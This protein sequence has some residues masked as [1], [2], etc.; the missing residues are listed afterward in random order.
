MPQP[1]TLHTRS[2]LRAKLDELGP[3]VWKAAAFSVAISF[4]QLV[5]VAYMFETFDRVVGSRS[6]ETLF[7]LTVI[8]V[9]ALAVLQGLEAVRSR[10]LESAA[11]QL[12]A[13]VRQRL[14]L[15]TFSARLMRHPSGS[16][17]A[18]NDLKMVRDFV[19]SP[20]LSAVLDLPASLLFVALIF[21]I[22]PSMGM[23][24]LIGVVIQFLLGVWNQGRSLPPLREAQQASAEATQ[25]AHTVARNAQVIDSMGMFPRVQ[26]RWLG[27]QRRF[28]LLQA[29]A[30]DGAAASQAA[31][32]MLGMVQ[33]SLIMGA[34]AFISLFAMSAGPASP[35]SVVD[36]AL[37]IIASILGGR[38]LLP[39][40]QLLLQ[41][42]MVAGVLQAFR[43]L[44][45]LLQT[46]PGRKPSMEL[47]APAGPLVVDQVTTGVPGLAQLILR[48]VSFAVRPG[49]VLAV[50]GPSG[51]G[52][53]TLAR[54][55]LGTWRINNGKVRLDGVDV[56][57][58]DKD[59]LGPYLGYLPQDVELFEGS[60]AD[61]IARFGEPDAE[62]L[63]EAVRLAG[64]E[65]IIAELPKGLQTNVGD[66]G[67]VLSGGQQQRVGLARAVYGTPRL[68]V[69]DEP[70]ASLDFEGERVLRSAI[71]ALRAAESI[72]VFV[73][74][75]RD[76][77]DLADLLLVLREGQVQGFGL[78]DQVLAAMYKSAEESRQRAAR[79]ATV[80]N[81]LGAAPRS[82][83][84]ESSI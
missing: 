54:V 50:I 78:R 66:L 44:D 45:D 48:G 42:R 57:L 33:G 80:P 82:G 9:F 47:P 59:Q 69:L 3:L 63:T 38:A 10:L 84:P 72:V 5:P 18:F 64:L 62:R 40:S 60:L 6:V 68:V 75:R 73:T 22:N 11:E 23:I 31:T 21:F 27:M 34:G 13:G 58:W 76:L 56:H 77:L 67:G 12:D 7:W 83:A 25:Y 74:H 53:S 39:L 16:G 49:Q 2:E 4:L 51:A 15:G 55:V 19:I 24:S 14:F 17:Q 79:F 30:S 32:R 37:L 28:L 1:Q 70:N 46:A 43:R 29:E 41:W 8:L 20:V 26:S 52:K 61:N 65:P 81:A 35:V 71:S 36:P